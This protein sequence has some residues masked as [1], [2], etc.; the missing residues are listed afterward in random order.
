MS[1][2]TAG[3]EAAS[4][5][6][7]GAGYVDG[8]SSSSGVAAGGEGYEMPTAEDMQRLSQGGGKTVTGPG[9]ED[10][11]G[12]EM[13]TAENMRRISGAS[14]QPAGTNAVYNNIFDR[15]YD[16]A[17]QSPAVDTGRGETGTVQE[18]A[19]GTESRGEELQDEM[20]KECADVDAVPGSASAKR[21][22][23]KGGKI[24]KGSQHRISLTRH[25]S[26]SAMVTNP[27]H[28]G[29]SA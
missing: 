22:K 1:G 9:D 28:R 5:A 21:S 8:S 16:L 18:T 6:L 17:S 19:F 23:T 29:T 14:S 13:P 12:Y 2:Q 15:D 25:N 27:L 24:K 11:E 10:K 4:A 26:T 20:F 7:D 3:N